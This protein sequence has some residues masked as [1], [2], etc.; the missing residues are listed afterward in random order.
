MEQLKGLVTLV[1]EAI[2]D[3][4]VANEWESAYK[5]LI[6]EGEKRGFQVIQKINKI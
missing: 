5:Y 4:D 6:A 1:Q 3:G 2:L